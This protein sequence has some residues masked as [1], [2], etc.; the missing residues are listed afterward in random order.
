MTEK[1]VQNG[2]C[3]VF[4][5]M[6]GS[7]SIA[8][9]YKFIEGLINKSYDG[10]YITIASINIICLL[11]LIISKFK[12]DTVNNVI[13]EKKMLDTVKNDNIFEKI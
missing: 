3:I 4:F 9:T 8:C 6:Y 1:S 2:I 7:I 5:I 12:K 11:V 10:V 13:E